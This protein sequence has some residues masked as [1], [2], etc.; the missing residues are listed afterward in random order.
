MKTKH[1]EAS[2]DLPVMISDAAVS[3]DFLPLRFTLTA[4]HRHDITQAPALIAG[5]TPDAVIADA[6]YDS[7]AF[8]AEARGTTMKIAR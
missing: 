2:Q 7:D 6:A 8:R 3:G 4:G 1:T 5:Y